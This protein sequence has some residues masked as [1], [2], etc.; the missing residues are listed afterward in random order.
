MP[1]TPKPPRLPEGRVMGDGK[2]IWM[3][4]RATPGCEGKYVTMI[5]SQNQGL[6]GTVYR[7]R[8]LTCKGTFHISR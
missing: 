7:Y 3:S 6:G 1:D 4:C 5:F 2:P 8:C